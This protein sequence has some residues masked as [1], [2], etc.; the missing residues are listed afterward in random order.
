MRINAPRH[1]LILDQLTD[2]FGPVFTQRD[3]ARIGVAPEVLRTLRLRGLAVP[4]GR[5]AFAAPTPAGIN[6]DWETFRRRA[7]GLG[8]TT[9]DEVYLS[10]WAA[11]A[12][13]GLPTIVDPPDEVVGIRL[14]YPHHGPSKSPG[15]RIRHGRVPMGHRRTRDRVLVISPAFTVVEVARHARPIDGLLV[16]DAAMHH[17]VGRETLAVLVGSMPHHPGIEQA[18]WVAEHAD[19]RAESPLETLGRFAFISAGQPAPLSNVWVTDG[20]N[21][22]RV[23]LLMPDTGVVL[24][25]DG[26]LKYQDGSTA[27]AIVK[28]EKERERILR[29]LGFGVVRFDFG[30]A[31]HR[32]GELVRR[33]AEEADRRVGPPPTRWSLD[34]VEL[35]RRA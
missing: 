24:E 25:G 20:V 28:A 29:K 8:L 30:L 22:Y 2:R 13:H 7:I 32:P 5:G 27:A 9:A 21:E 10:E 12:L 35:L 19:P 18:A 1:Q 33:A 26:D 3:A 14:G 34:R 23:D 11:V 4:V 31:L 16:A 17:G 6:H 15:V